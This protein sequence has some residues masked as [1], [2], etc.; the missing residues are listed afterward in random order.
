MPKKRKTVKEKRLEKLTEDAEAMRYFA[1]KENPVLFARTLGITPD[2]WQKTALQSQSNRLILCCSRQSGKT[3]VTSIIAVHHAIFND[4][5]MVL[6]ISRTWPQAKE[7]FKRISTFYKQ[8]DFAPKSTT[9]SV[10]RLELA[11]GSR[12]IALSGA[13]PNSARGYSGVSLLILDEASHVVEETYDVVRPTLAVS[14]GRIVLLSTPHGRRGFFFDSWEEATDPRRENL[15]GWEAIQV[16]AEQV[17]RIS[18]EFLAQEREKYPAWFFDQ[19]YG[20]IFHTNV[21]NVFRDV[22]TVFDTVG[23][24]DDEIWQFSINLPEG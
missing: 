4:N 22:E 5:S 19:E 12:I 20:C 21:S 15:E 2:D 9:D 24:E 17:P 8:V 10:H 1:L 3:T 7:I 6:I 23:E 14:G 13:Q 16:T 11:N 18:D